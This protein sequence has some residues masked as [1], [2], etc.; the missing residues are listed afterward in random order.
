MATERR[1]AARPKPT[2][3]VLGA[4]AG[5]IAMG[6]RLKRAGYEFTIYER[7]DGVGGTWRDNTYP[8]AA[9][10]VPSHLYSYSFELNPW[11]SRTY[12]TQPEILAYLERCT[13]QYGVRPHVRTG[14]AITEARWDGDAHQWVLTSDEGE[15]F[16]ADVVVSG[17][18]ML[19]VPDIPDI[20]GADRFRGRAFHSSRWDH[21]KSVAGERVGSIGTG[22]SA[23]QYVP[24]IAPEAEHVTV[25]QRTPIWI[26]PRFDTPYTPEEQRRFARVPFAA[27]RHRFQIWYQYQQ[28]DF[29]ADGEQT[30][31]Q[32]EL[33]KSYLARKITDPELA[34][35]LT[36]D[37]PVG[38]KRPLI[39]RDWLPALTRDDVRVVTEPIVEITE[40]G[41]RTADGELHEVDT[42]VYGTGFKAN[43]F[44]STIDIIGEG[45]RRL[46]DDWRDGAEAYL[47]LSVAG[48]PNLFLLYGPNTNGVNSIIFFHEAQTH[49]VLAALGTMRGLG[50]ASVDVRR[51]T[52]D[53]Y[54]ERIQAALQG[55]VWLAGCRNY[56]R[57]ASGKVVTQLPFSGGWY[58]A[59]TR[60]FPAWRYRLRRRRP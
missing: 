48:Y 60:I 28:A 4:G 34:A 12:A 13:D 31:M 40:T 32:T 57:A 50:V 33:A 2:V 10:D 36:P 18:G 21:S 46:H 53:R 25:F 37:Y 58:W 29:A 16:R 1:R 35:V 14:C 39:S 56:F 23:I 49:F 42:I 41:L 30:L 3:A 59:R 27:R 17:L 19:N 7:S 51:R 9:C 45:G 8:G 54:N 43:E 26:T 20:P 47:G 6:I 11:W 24:A 44:L 22:A 15:R 5:G 38:C 52:M 55:T